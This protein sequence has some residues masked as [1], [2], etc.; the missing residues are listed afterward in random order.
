[1]NAQKTT[2]STLRHARSIVHNIR[3]LIRLALD[4]VRKNDIEYAEDLVEKAISYLDSLT[5]LLDQIEKKLSRRG[6]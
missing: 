1:M 2:V 4:A 3:R 5:D 6:S